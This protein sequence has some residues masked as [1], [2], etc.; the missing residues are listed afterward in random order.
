MGEKEKERKSTR[1]WEHHEATWCIQIPFEEFRTQF[2]YDRPH[3]KLPVSPPNRIGNIQ[4]KPNIIYLYLGLF[5]IAQERLTGP[6]HPLKCCPTVLLYYTD[7]FGLIQVQYNKL[8]RK[9][10]CLSFQ[11]KNRSK[12]F[13][14][15][16]VP[17]SFLWGPYIVRHIVKTWKFE[18]FLFQKRLK[19]STFF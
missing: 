1:L 11:Q 16:A 5:R 2:S 9:A 15:L 6:S 7:N 8:S 17:Q 14:T 18:K 19:T 12:L 4:G 3:K 10:V 13:T